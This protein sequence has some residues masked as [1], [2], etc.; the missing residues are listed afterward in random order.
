MDDTEVIVIAFSD[1]DFEDDDW[2][3]LQKSNRTGI[4]PVLF[5]CRNN[6]IRKIIIILRR[7]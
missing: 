7:C 5:F 2:S 3:H 4:N 6:M 1:E